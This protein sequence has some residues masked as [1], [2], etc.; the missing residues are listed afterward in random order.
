[1]MGTHRRCYGHMASSLCSCV[2]PATYHGYVGQG[3]EQPYGAHH[4]RRQ[5]STQQADHGCRH[6]LSGIGRYHFRVHDTLACCFVRVDDQ[7]HTAPVGKVTV[8]PLR[9]Y[10]DPVLEAN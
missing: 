10:A 5:C 2:R 7:P 8:R 4:G 1:M 3:G 6:F 9:Q